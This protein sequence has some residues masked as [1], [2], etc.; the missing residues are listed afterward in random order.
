MGIEFSRVRKKKKKFKKT[1]ILTESVLHPV[2]ITVLHD[3][4]RPSDVNRILNRIQVNVLAFPSLTQPKFD[5]SHHGLG[6]TQCPSHLQSRLPYLGIRQAQE[7]RIA[8][9]SFLSMMSEM[10]L[11]NLFAHLA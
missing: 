7:P 5:S 2:R 6:L 11:G 9:L 3:F 10:S 8:A 4:V 1:I